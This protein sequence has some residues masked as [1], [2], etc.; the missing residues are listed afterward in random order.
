M[1]GKQTCYPNQSNFDHNSG[2]IRGL[3][4]QYSPHAEA[5]Y[6]CCLRGIVFDVVLDLRKTHTHMDI[7]SI[8]LN[9]S[10]IRLWLF[11]RVV[12]MDFKQ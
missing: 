1:L 10:N 9:A 4:F 6:V 2:V 8:E 5:K 3:H 7:F 12:L 11:L